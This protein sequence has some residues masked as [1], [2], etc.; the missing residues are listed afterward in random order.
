M[1]RYAVLLLAGLSTMACACSG[2]IP[3]MSP[4]VPS[5]STSGTSAPVIK[6]PEP[7]LEGEVSLEEALLRRRSVREYANL[8]LSLGEI[9]QLLW[10]AQGVT[11]ERGGR[12]AP[13]AGALYPLEVYLVAGSVENLA[14]GV[15]KYKPA[16]QQLI[17]VKGQDVR[18][19][20]AGAALEQTCVREAAI[21]IVI[22]AVYERTTVKYGDR[23]VRYVYIEAGH[24]AQNICLQATALELGVVTVGAFY[25]DKVKTAL[26]MPDN[27]EPL[28]IISVG[29]SRA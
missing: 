9:S 18:S 16:G 20:L 13:S 3:G 8:P 22:A 29:R 15:Y 11:S 2:S 21:N 28:Y 4:V 17:K 27:E 23:G 6:L 24:S 19:E 14:S 10:A 1:Y 5:A 25:D 26:D 7:V 12:T